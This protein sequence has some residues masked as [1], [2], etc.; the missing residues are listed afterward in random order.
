MLDRPYYHFHSTSSALK[1]LYNPDPAYF[2]GFRM[3]LRT[4]YFA[5]TTSQIK[6]VDSLSHLFWHRM[7]IHTLGPF[8]SIAV[9]LDG[10]GS[11]LE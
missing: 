7:E 10:T 9:C 5:D 11:Y 6:S 2:C 3:I 1:S 4:K 8:C